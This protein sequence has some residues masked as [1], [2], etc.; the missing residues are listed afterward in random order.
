MDKIKY[1][2]NKKDNRSEVYDGDKLIG[3]CDYKIEA[4]KLDI[5]HTE[6]DP[7]YSGRGLAGKLV[8]LVVAYARDENLKIIPSCPYVAKKFD[9][10]ESYKDVDAR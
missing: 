7:A 5:Y 8:D 3:K 10:D 4:D 9:K 1:I 2:L 6:V